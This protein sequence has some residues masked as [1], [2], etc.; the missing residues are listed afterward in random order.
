MSG[1]ATVGLEHCASYD[2]DNLKEFF[3]HSFGASPQFSPRTAKIFIKPNLI[4]ARGPRLACTHG[5]FLLA[6]GEFLVDNGA[7]VSVGDSPAFGSASMVLRNLG[8]ADA[9]RLRGISIINFK[10]VAHRR[11]ECGVDLGIAAEPLSY[12]Y[13]INAPK[14]K[15][16]SQMYVTLA[17]KNLFGI[18][19]GMR[20][21][22]LHMRHGGP[23]NMFSRIIVDLIQHLPPNFSVI[24]GVQAMHGTGPVHGTA[25][26]FGCVGFSADPVALDT[27]ILHAL[28]LDTRRS[29][30]W[31][32]AER[33]GYKGTDINNIQFPMLRPEFFHGSRFQAPQ[34]LS[35]IRFNPFRFFWNSLKRVAGYSHGQ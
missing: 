29:P 16:H 22:M 27:S 34:Q 18:V 8:V 17:V 15:A 21:S 5:G 23:D 26:D 35:P 25:L 6:L 24:D 32:E 1:Q 20:K 10:K 11:L 31:C 2:N 30:L 28:E 4:S 13:F 33:R 12:D 7:Q 3:E 19:L 14:I 9:L